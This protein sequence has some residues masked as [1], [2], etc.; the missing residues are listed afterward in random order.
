M[1]N[2]TFWQ[3]HVT[4][5]E[6]RFR[7]Q[8]NSDGTI[9]HIPVE[10]E[11]L[12]EGTPQNAA[13]FTNIETGIFSA[14]ETAAELARIALQQGRG[15]NALSGET[16]TITLKNTSVYPFNN[17]VKSVS[18]A[19]IRD[20]EEYTVDAYVTAPTDGGSVGRIVITDKLKNG[21]KI[22]YTGGAASVTVK[23]TVRGGAI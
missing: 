23:Y 3:D 10:G 4:Q 22:A 2:R 9:S 5:Y 13:N 6:N 7:E 1:Y 20:T 11:V 8:N 14:H 17:S 18:L 12:Q 21:F 15:I 19:K 16:G